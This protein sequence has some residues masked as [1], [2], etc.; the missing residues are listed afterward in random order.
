MKKECIGR[1]AKATDEHCSIE[2]KCA[3]GSTASCSGV[4]C[5]SFVLSGTLVVH[6]V[7]EDGNISGRQCTAPSGTVVEIATSPEKACAYDGVSEGDSCT[8]RESGTLY[9][10]ICYHKGNGLICGTS[11]SGAGSGQFAEN[12]VEACSGHQFQE[13]C[14][15]KGTLDTDPHIGRCVHSTTTAN[16]LICSDKA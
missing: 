3:D 10:G 9:S 15:W 1:S 14:S 13:P 6:C 7:D 2:K 5:V 8:W 4:D 11:G 12:P 16:R